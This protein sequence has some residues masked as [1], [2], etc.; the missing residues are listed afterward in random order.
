M[1][2]H[3]ARQGEITHNITQVKHANRIKHLRVNI[4]Q[5]L[6]LGHI[7]TIVTPRKSNDLV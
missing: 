3:K 4:F 5:L 1:A 2:F 6:H 7:H